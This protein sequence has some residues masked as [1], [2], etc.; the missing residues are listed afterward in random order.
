ML[1][2][3]AAIGA[4]FIGAAEEAALVVFLFAVGEVLEGVAADKARDSIR[5]LADLVPKTAY[6]EENG[7]IREVEASTLAIGQIILAR[8]GDRYRGRWRYC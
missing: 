6:V 1:M 3:I 7:S 5:A 2:T 4:L 8:P